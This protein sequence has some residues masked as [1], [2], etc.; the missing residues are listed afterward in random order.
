VGREVWGEGC[1]ARGVGSVVSGEG[2]GASLAAANAAVPAKRLGRSDFYPSR[3]QRGATCWATGGRGVGRVEGRGSSRAT[4]TDRQ[5]ESA[6]VRRYPSSVG[7]G[8]RPA[9]TGRLVGRPGPLAGAE[10]LASPPL[11]ALPTLPLLGRRGRSRRDEVPRR[12]RGGRIQTG[13]Y[14]SRDEWVRCAGPRIPN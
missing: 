5:S 4:R 10:Q 3:P 2:C 9:R 7:P 13:I 12:R 1:G 8:R 11:P 14:F 6:A